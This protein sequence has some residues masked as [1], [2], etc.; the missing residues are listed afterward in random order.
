MKRSRDGR[1]AR[2]KNTR[3][4]EEVSTFVR[5][6]RCRKAVMEEFMDG[7]ARAYRCRLGEG[8]A[9]CDVCEGIGGEVGG[10]TRAEAGW[11][12]QG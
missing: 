10:E 1:V 9:G 3:A 4:G 11:C 6:E 7:D 12:Y 8:E 2:E 5:G